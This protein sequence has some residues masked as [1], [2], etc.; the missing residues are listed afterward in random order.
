ML[1]SPGQWGSLR[2]KTKAAQHSNTGSAKILV[3]APQL[4]SQNSAHRPEPNYCDSFCGTL[5]T[6]RQQVNFQFNNGLVQTFL[7]LSLFLS[8]FPLI[9]LSAALFSGSGIHVYAR[10][11]LLFRTAEQSVRPVIKLCFLL[12]EWIKSLNHTVQRSCCYLIG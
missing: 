3:F 1:W 9:S 10:L 11:A 12:P 2:N 5:P 6:H 7:V 8:H 4:K